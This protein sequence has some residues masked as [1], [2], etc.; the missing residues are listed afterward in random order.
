MAKG[1]GQA[2]HSVTNTS[3]STTKGNDW[4]VVNLTPSRSQTPGLQKQNLSS[5]TIGV[6]HSNSFDAL[7][8]DVEHDMNKPE[9]TDQQLEDA[10]RP[11]IG[12]TGYTGSEKQQK[13]AEDQNAR[14][15]LVTVNDQNCEQTQP[16]DEA[17]PTLH[18]SNPELAQMVPSQTIDS[19]GEHVDD[20]GQR[21][22]S[23]GNNKQANDCLASL[24]QTST[25]EL[26]NSKGQQVATSAFILYQKTWTDQAQDEEDEDEHISKIWADQVE[27]EEGNEVESMDSYV[28]INKKNASPTNAHK[29]N[30]PRPNTTT[31]KKKQDIVLRTSTSPQF[32]Q[33]QQLTADMKGTEI[34]LHT[35]EM[36]KK[37]ATGKTN[38]N[39]LA[40]T[41]KFNLTPTNI[42]HALVTYDM[43]TLRALDNPRND[44][45]AL[46]MSGYNHSDAFGIKTGQDWYEEGEEE[47]LLDAHFKNVA[48]EGDL[49]LR[50]IR[51]GSNKNKKKA[52]ERQHSWDGKA[53]QDFVIRKPPMRTAKQKPSVPTTS[54]RSNKSKNK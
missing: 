51:S 38:G 24:T 50:K 9:H 15:Q 32:Q 8:Y 19:F 6:S 12:N 47:E 18:I 54:T 40:L 41:T 1:A 48:R 17:T 28:A 52:H 53:T 16:V 7:L 29:F 37:V 31:W 25:N 36:H 46:V 35:K 39:T 21:L 45:G 11:T 3:N 49:S 4:K 2:R 34:F 44:Q 14:L 5:N 22:L 20:S 26:T 33:G 10:T 23:T 43:D 42:L 13:K 27:E 30:T